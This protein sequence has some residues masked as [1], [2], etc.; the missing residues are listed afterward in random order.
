MSPNLPLLDLGQPPKTVYSPVAGSTWNELL[1]L[2]RRRRIR[3]IICAL[4]AIGIAMMYTKRQTPV[5]QATSVVRFEPDQVNL[6]Q[7]VQQLS[8]EN[9]VSTEIEMLQGYS[10]ARVAVDSSGWRAQ[11][12]VPRRAQPSEL[13]AVLNVATD[14]DTSTFELHR[15]V[16]GNFVVIGNGSR[17]QVVT[18]HVGDT[19]QVNGVT[20]ALKPAA[21]REPVLQVHV[22]SLANAVQSLRSALQVTRPARDADLISIR[23]QSSDPVRAAAA[24]NFLAQHLIADRQEVQMAR[25]G[26]TVHFLTYQLDT[27]GTQLRASEDSLRAY[28]ERVGVVDAPEQAHSE[29]SRLAQVQA[30]RASIEAERNALAALV[31][32]LREPT[33]PQ[34]VGQVP[35]KL[36]VSFPT[37]LRNPATSQLLGDLA[38][39]EDERAALLA[40]RK[41]QDPDVL[42]LTTRVNNLRA[43]LQGIG[44]TYLEGLS[45]QVA[46]LNAA[47]RSFGESL[48]SLPRQEVETARLTRE[49]SVRQDLFT[50]LQT[51]LKE[52]EI[53]QSMKDETLRI[54]DPATIPDKPV[55]P[56]LLVNLLAALGFG[57]AFGI[58]GS[59]IRELTDPAV[60]S[61]GDALQASGLPVLGAIPRISVRGRLGTTDHFS[62]LR[63]PPKI[64][65]KSSVATPGYITARNRSAALI[66]ARMITS[67]R[68]P[69]SYTE[70]FTQ[71]YVNL[72]LAYQRTPLKSIVFTSSLP[73]EGKTLSAI[74]LSIAAAL[75]GLR[76]LLIDGDLRCGLVSEVFKCPRTPGF[77]EVLRNAVCFED[78]YKRVPVGE[79]ATLAILPPGMHLPMQGR[80]QPTSRIR[81]VLDAIEEHFDLIVIDSPPVNVLTDAA[82]LGSAADGVVVVVRTGRTRIDALRYGLDQLTVAQAAV[83]GTV[84]NDIDLRRNGSD[85]GSYRYLAE[86][87]RYYVSH[88]V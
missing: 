42:A 4:V 33:T 64:D 27:L 62:R 7:L 52:A 37:L 14:A 24:A 6:P 65:R 88:T 34:G 25:T 40:R 29:V 50:L 81:E 73:G 20:F 74:N 16:G 76:V 70:S 17:V 75:R 39:V 77:A 38:K 8:S 26:S 48:D 69:A 43:Q 49:V 87:E 22:M 63:L 41:P 58:G 82:L 72:M 35:A 59:L 84:L 10:A 71:L 55:R 54:V 23:V 5:Y 36:L 21:R 86:V 51:R 66:A 30:D 15:V 11:L 79:S 13:F 1:A 3:V 68:S 80:L 32:Q 67:P 47:A 31:Q 44:E 2:V 83:I 9:R 45:N 18:I 53:T 85:D 19:I 46:S 12:S 56:I 28:Q 60:R 57:L 78:A 61:R